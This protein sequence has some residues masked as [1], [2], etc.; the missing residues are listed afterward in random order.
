MSRERSAR[1]MKIE[2]KSRGHNHEEKLFKTVMISGKQNRQV[3]KKEDW[4]VVTRISNDYFF[5]QENAFVLFLGK[6]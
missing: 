3:S 5:L 4:K 1:E 2:M 6:K